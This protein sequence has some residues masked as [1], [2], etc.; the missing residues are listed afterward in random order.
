MSEFTIR[1]ARWPDDEAA[2]VSFID[3][4]Q[5][6]E[7]VFESNRRLDGAVGAEFFAELVKHAAE[8]EGRIFV[9]ERNGAAVG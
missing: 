2:A 3:G 8:N 6:Y 7:S 4:L 9:A 5:R 1:D